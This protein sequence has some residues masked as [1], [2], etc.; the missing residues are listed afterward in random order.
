MYEYSISS[1]RLMSKYESITMGYRQLVSQS[2][3]KRKYNDGRNNK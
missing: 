3:Q 1:D 2:V